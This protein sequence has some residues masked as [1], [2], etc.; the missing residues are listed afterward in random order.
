MFWQSIMMRV[1]SAR[2]AG[3][4]GKPLRARRSWAQTWC[5]LGAVRRCGECTPRLS[6]MPDAGGQTGQ[7]PSAS[8]LRGTA[9][10]VP[11]RPLGRLGY[12]CASRGNGELA[13]ATPRAIPFSCLGGS[14]CILVER[15]AATLA[16]RTIDDLGLCPRS[17]AVL[18]RT[19]AR[20]SP[21]AGDCGRSETL[22]AGSGLVQAGTGAVR[23]RASGLAS[24][25]RHGWMRGDRSGGSCARSI[26]ERECRRSCRVGEGD[27]CRQS[28]HPGP[29]GHRHAERRPGAGCQAPPV[30][31]ED[32][33]PDAKAGHRRPEPPNAAV[34]RHARDRRDNARSR[35]RARARARPRPRERRVPG[36][37]AGRRTR[38]VAS[39]E[40]VVVQRDCAV[41]CQ[42]PTVDVRARV[43][44]ERM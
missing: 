34:R 37:A 41:P 9:T 16:D 2:L 15:A 1:E 44:G 14:S 29:A 35:A 6:P 19:C 20:Y 39:G 31:R 10:N 3:V 26:R 4:E 33:P 18:A 43:Q 40:R 13:A 22:I 38:A 36:S 5:P 30:E 25:R 7:C 12:T 8:P 11:P 21:H 27:A 24:E 42:R 17:G 32:D 23:R 28:M